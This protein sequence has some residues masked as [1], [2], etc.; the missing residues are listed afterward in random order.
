MKY[1]LS[2]QHTY[3][4]EQNEN[5]VEVKTT[6]FTPGVMWKTKVD[7]LYTVPKGNWSVMK[8]KRDEEVSYV[9]FMNTM[10]VETIDVLKKKIS[11]ILDDL[12]RTKPKDIVDGLS[13]IDPTFYP[14]D[15]NPRCRW[16]K[17][18]LFDIC[19]SSAYYVVQTCRNQRRLQ[20]FFK[21]I[22]GLM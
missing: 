9:D 8:F 14:P 1:V 5:I 18:M 13:I 20:D 22:C 19:R 6:Y 7:Y 11:I 3:D 16:Q 2:A 10:L 15:T 4:V 12:I 21:F 17:E